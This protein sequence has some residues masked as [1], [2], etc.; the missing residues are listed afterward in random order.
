MSMIE[1]LKL[2]AVW[3]R[4]SVKREGMRLLFNGAATFT[5]TTLGIMPFSLAMLSITTLGIMPFPIMTLTITHL[6]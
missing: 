5:I 3:L 4:K 2:F 1:T 6:A